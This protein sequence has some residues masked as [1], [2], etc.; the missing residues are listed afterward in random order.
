MPR[1]RIQILPTALANQIA[2]GEVV[3]RPASV[4]KEFLENSLD[5]GADQ[6]DVDVEAGGVKLIRVRDNGM[7]IDADDLALALA[8]HATSKVVQASDLEAISTLG[9]RG[10]ALAS[11]ASV[12]HLRVVSCAHGA[13]HAWAYDGVGDVVPAAHPPGTSVEARDL[14]YNTPA[15]RRFLRSE[16]TE[17]SHIEETVRRLALART[18]VG[19]SLRHNGRVLIDLAAVTSNAELMRRVAAVCGQPFADV[20][21]VTEHNDGALRLHGWLGHPT[22]SRGLPDLQFLFVNGRLVRDRMVAAAVRRAYADVLFGTRHPAWLL[23]L[24]IDPREVDVNVHPTKH[25]VRFRDGRSVHDFV[26]RAVRDTVRQIDSGNIARSLDGGAGAP[27]EQ[28]VEV[29]A[30]GVSG[31]SS[32]TARGAQWQS[33]QPAASGWLSTPSAFA[34]DASAP[35][36][37]SMP[38]L[39][40]PTSVSVV[41]LDAAHGQRSG[42]YVSE[43]PDPAPSAAAGGAPAL[44]FAI[45]QLHGIY[46]LAQNAEGLVLVDMHG[47]HER[48]TFERMKRALA[49]GA[50]ASQRLL[51]PVRV[52]VTPREAQLAESSADELAQLGL[53]LDRLGPAELVVREV[54][55][56]LAFVDAAALLREVLAAAGDH[57]AAA[58][59]QR[60][61]DEL[62]A[63]IAC[64]S[65]VRAQRRLTLPEMNQLLR[66]IETTE[67]GGQCSH[68][69]PTVV[70]MELKDID[71]LFLRGR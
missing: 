28:R 69:R 61:Q 54:P 12:S 38:L 29:F 67:C 34:T 44:G 4:L 47:A 31:E 60:S 64:H 39:Q 37:H 26:F 36:Q 63:D 51:V 21:L 62:L 23:Y 68:G 46:V 41:Q 13:A 56:A 35:A 19:F 10:E 66:D 5:A 43:V 53:V 71:R 48:I 11:I 17:L 45:A 49:R 33:R 65:A 14:F 20:A 6:I 55:A 24:E 22:F 42:D 15:R 52:A 50:L 70:Q 1:A 8:R 16:R 3:E 59:L 58:Q 40:R 32:A 18:E 27:M 30:S 25:E 57:G 2:A 9:F 7:G